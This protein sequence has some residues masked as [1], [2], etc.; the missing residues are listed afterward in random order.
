MIPVVY[1]LLTMVCC[2]FGGLSIAC[3]LDYL[4]KKRYFHFGLSVMYVASSLMLMA[5]LVF[6]F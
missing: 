4:N 2:A 1:I 5:K 6:T 3:A